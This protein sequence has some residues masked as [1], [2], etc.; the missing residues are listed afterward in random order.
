MDR[1][2]F[3]NKLILAM[4]SLVSVS[5]GLL[6]YLYINYNVTGN[7]FQFSIYQREHWSQRFY[8]FFDTVRYQIEYAVNTFKDA[9][10]RS[11]LG[12]WLPNLSAIFLV[13]FMMLRSAKKLNPAYMAYMIAYFVYVVAPT[14]LLSAPRYF[15]VAFPLAFAAVLLTEDKRW[16]DILLTT[17]FIAGGLLYLAVFVSGYPV[18]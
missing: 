13:L 3:T 7:A 2:A 16:K 9:D 6:A 11:F 17:L 15:A 5:F 10:Y 12:L 8:F 4:V 1:K 14:W 18:Y